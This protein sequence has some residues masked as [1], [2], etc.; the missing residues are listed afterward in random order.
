MT[1]DTIRPMASRSRHALV[2]MVLLATTLAVTA[3]GLVTYVWG[4]LDAAIRPWQRGLASTGQETEGESIATREQMLR[5]GTEN[6]LL[7]TRLAE[8]E[9][10]RGE[11]GLDPQQAVVVRARI[12]GRTVRSGR[13]YVEL[14]AGALDGVTKGMP[15]CAGWSLVGVVSGLQDGRCLVQQVTDSGSRIPAAI[16]GGK[17]VLAEGVLTG[18]GKRG[19][20]ELAFVEDRPGLAIVPGLTVVTVGTDERIPSGLVLGTVREANRSSTADHWRIAVAPLRT[21]D[22]AES[23]LVLGFTRGAR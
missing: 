14:D 2:G 6:T 20:L 15:V 4:R 21:A 9:A 19:Q 11:G 12:V 13:R 22:A 23:L 8:Y 18:T 17:E 5:L 3:S 1:P 7:R 10:I 16:L